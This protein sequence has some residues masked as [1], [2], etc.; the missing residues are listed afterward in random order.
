MDSEQGNYGLLAEADSMLLPDYQP[1]V[2]AGH[3]QPSWHPTWGAVGAL[4]TK[5][6]ETEA[7][8]H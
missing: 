8:P 4:D 7:H 5:G 6:W 3:T 1:S 2:A